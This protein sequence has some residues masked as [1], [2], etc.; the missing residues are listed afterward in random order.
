LEGDETKPPAAGEPMDTQIIA[1]FCLCDDMPKALHHHENPQ[2]QMT[3]A[4]V[5]TTAILAA[6]RFGGNFE[7][8]RHLLLT[9]GYIPHMLGKSRFPGLSGQDR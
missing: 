5:M 9:E 1:I 3:D 8:A 4:E 6:L 2:S 7:Q